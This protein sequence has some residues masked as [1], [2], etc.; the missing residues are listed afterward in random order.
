MTELVKDLEHLIWSY[1]TI[2]ILLFVSLIFTF[3]LRGVQFKFKTMFNQE[4]S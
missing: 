2:P 4:N 3:Y 1:L